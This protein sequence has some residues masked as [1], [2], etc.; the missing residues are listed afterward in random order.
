M[1]G[2]A[3]LSIGRYNVL[4]LDSCERR[5]VLRPDFGGVL[6]VRRVGY[7]FHTRGVANNLRTDAMQV[8]GRIR[9]LR[10]RIIVRC[11]VV[12]CAQLSLQPWSFYTWFQRCEEVLFSLVVC[13]LYTG[14][15][16]NAINTRCAATMC[17]DASV[18]ATMRVRGETH[19]RAP[20]EVRNQA[21]V[22]DCAALRRVFGAH[23]RTGAVLVRELIRSEASAVFAACLANQNKDEHRAQTVSVATDQPSRKLCLAMLSVF[24][25]VCVLLLGP[26]HAVI[27]YNQALWHTWSQREGLRRAIMNKSNKRDASNRADYRGV[28]FAGVPPPSHIAHQHIIRS[29]IFGG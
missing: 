29:M 20:K 10:P 24:C 8:H 27:V 6:R 12:N 18:L 4:V 14:Y 2:L 16:Q 9:Q 3:T 1:L 5:H 22:P 19:Y 15:C 21:P 23:W 25:N 13:M 11:R 26:V 28:L 17:M 7:T